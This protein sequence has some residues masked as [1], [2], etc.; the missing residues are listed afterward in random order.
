VE[1]EMVKRRVQTRIEC[2]RSGPEE[3]LVAI[4][5]PLVDDRTLEPRTS[6]DA[7]DQDE[8]YRHHDYLAP[9]AGSKLALKEPSLA[10]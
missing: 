1:I 10:E 8:C 3:W 4:R 5:R 2:K 7:T 6:R 9:T